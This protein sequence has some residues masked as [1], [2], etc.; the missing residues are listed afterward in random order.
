MQVLVVQEEEREEETIELGAKVGKNE[1]HEV[2]ELS[3][4]SVVELSTPRTMKVTEFL[5]GQAVVVLIDCGATHNFISLEL[6]K[7][8]NILVT[9]TNS[10]GVTMNRYYGQRRGNM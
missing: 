3:I 10:Y 1:V 2:V 6:V 9:G 7:K 5:L 4:N 8:L